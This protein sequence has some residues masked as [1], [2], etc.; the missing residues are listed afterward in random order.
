MCFLQN[1][2][3]FVHFGRLLQIYINF[4]RFS[5]FLQNV[6]LPL[7]EADLHQAPPPSRT[8][9][10]KLRKHLLLLLLL[11][12]PFQYGCHRGGVEA[13]ASGEAAAGRARRSEGARRREGGRGE[14][15]RG[16]GGEEESRVPWTPPNRHRGV[17]GRHPLGG[18]GRVNGVR[19]AAGRRQGAE[20][21]HGRGAA[22][23]ATVRA[24]PQEEE[25][26]A[27]AAP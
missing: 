5:R 18:C 10:R 11:L 2:I 1:E 27:L 24:F 25:L 6:A 3:K 16:R 9:S 8:S 22:G 7:S 20:P 26:E 19:S 17:G 12:L 13:A 14:E 23:G 21:F 15:E 4:G